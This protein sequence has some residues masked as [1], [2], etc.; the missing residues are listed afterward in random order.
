MTGVLG[1]GAPQ[2]IFTNW[3][4]LDEVKD[5]ESLFSLFEIKSSPKTRPT[6][7]PVFKLPVKIFKQFDDWKTGSDHCGLEFQCLLTSTFLKTNIL[8]SKIGGLLMFL[9]FQGGDFYSWKRTGR[10]NPPHLNFR[11]FE[12][13]RW[14]LSILWV[15]MAI[16]FLVA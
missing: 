15:A 8:N 5:L 13:S 4:H 16:A 3:W 2:N 11:K 7:L 6:I 9:L 10:D 14:H 12:G 1:V